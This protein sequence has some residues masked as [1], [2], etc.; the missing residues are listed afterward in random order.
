VRGLS[1]HVGSQ[2]ADSAKHVEALNACVKLMAS[3]RREK[4]G[5]STPSISVAA[6]RSTTHS[7]CR[8]SADSAKPIREALTKLPKR[9]RVVAEPG[10]FIVGPSRLVSPSDGSRQA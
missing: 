6:F 8:T 9:V 2:A 5:H 3:A 10:R 7:R 4:L 1:F